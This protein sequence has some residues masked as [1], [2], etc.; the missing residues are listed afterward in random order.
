MGWL[1]PADVSGATLITHDGLFGPC[2]PEVDESTKSVRLVLPLSDTDVL[3]ALRVRLRLAE[4]W[5]VL[6]SGLKVT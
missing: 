1:N 2:V 5:V 3:K 4:N 6:V